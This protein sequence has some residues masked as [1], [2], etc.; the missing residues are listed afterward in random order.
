[1]RKQKLDIVHEKRELCSIFSQMEFSDAPHES[2]GE[3]DN[4]FQP[5]S[6]TAPE[7]TYF[8]ISKS[9]Q[10]IILWEKVKRN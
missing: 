8:L 9:N 5:I 2:Q 10:M 7:K 6:Y 3:I 1:M 4:S